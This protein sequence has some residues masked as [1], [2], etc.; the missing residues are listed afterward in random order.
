MQLN[1]RAILMIAGLTALAVLAVA[2]LLIESSRPP[3]GVTGPGPSALPP[4]AAESFGVN[5]NRLFND[6]TFG[7]SQID[8]QLAALQATGATIARS[9]ALWEASEPQA[10]VN[11]VHRYD[12]SFDDRIAGSLAAH[13]LR[14]L[15]IIDYSA[16]WAQ[17]IRG[18][19]HSPPSSF[20]D[21]AAYAA[22]FTKR[23]GAGGTFWPAH[24]QLH[25]LPVN[26]FEIW[27]EPDNP[28]FWRPEPSAAGYAR[29]YIAA[30]DAIKS[31]DPQ[32]RVIVGGLTAPATFLPSMLA[33][34]P[35]LR[36][37]I[38]GVAIHPY[39]ADP[40]AVLSSVSAAREALDALGM[41]STPL[42]VTEFGWVTHPAGALD[43]AP[44]RLRAIYIEQTLAALGHTRCELAAALLYTWV[45]P[46][47]DLRDR[48]DWY[49]I[50]PPTG[51]VTA[52]MRAFSAGLRA[53]GP[54]APDRS[55]TSPCAGT[56][57]PR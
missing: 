10:P 46:M 1:R 11:G 55:R 27:N 41:D 44:A 7:Q 56:I 36:T 25:P 5:V 49:G 2:A 6:L 14:W 34:Q 39:G 12:W 40:D 48:E 28:E 17:S 52:A 53:A 45:T 16:G 42:Y 31:V 35:A 4:P 21:Y 37:R 57:H 30:R 54:R 19:D 20:A 3:R 22:A 33:A 38:D 32:A 24:P 15:P 47:R 18:V 8:L 23:Y 9:D 29:L 50:S 51:G 43:Y 13:G 26:T